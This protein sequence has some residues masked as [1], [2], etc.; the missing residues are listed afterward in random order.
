MLLPFFISFLA[1][2]A[3]IGLL[4]RR[5]R[6]VDPLMH[7]FLSPGVGL[8][9]CASLT[10]LTIILQD[11]FIAAW[12]I[13]ACV[14]ATLALLT[15]WGL[16]WRSAKKPLFAVERFALK[17]L[18]LV[19]VLLLIAWYSWIEASLYPL[20]GW[21]AW[22]SWN[23]KSKFIF[24]GGEH[25]KDMFSPVLWR[26]SPHYPLLL[27]LMNVWGWSFSGSTDPR[28]PMLTSI[29]FTVATAGLLFAA[30]RTLTQKVTGLAAVV[31]LWSLPLFISLATSQYCDIVLAYFLLGAFACLLDGTRKN[32][33][34]LLGIAGLSAGF[35]SFTKT[36]GVAAAGLF[37]ILAAWHL[38]LNLSSRPEKIRLLKWLIGGLVLA[39]IPTVIFHFVYAPPNITFTNGWT[40]STDPSGWPRL[41]MTL[42]F[43]LAEIGLI[44][45]HGR[46][47]FLNE[48][49]NWVLALLLWGVVL[50][51]VRAFG[52][53]LRI[54]PAFIAGYLIILIAYYYT[55][56]Y[57]EI[58]W[59]LQV[60]LDRVLFALLPTL[61][62]W[63]WVAFKDAR[64]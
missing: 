47:F 10:F 59:W 9:L 39:G 42:R 54:F 46:V 20:G 33:P 31:L 15:V 30:I 36:E 57:F 50:N 52:R 4:D 25:W 24:L 41:S 35:L 3:L 55:N 56:T 23:L 13:G 40:S 22:S 18:G 14:L 19:P 5:G 12:A 21:D 49:W 61:A 1:G 7:L 28:I 29:V 26:S 11:R 53:G 60:T 43:L 6:T 44:V 32:S 48:K 34:A 62:L 63:V 38:Q 2:F 8:G 16:E 64:S 58:V 45:D 27:P 17:D 51:A 37:V